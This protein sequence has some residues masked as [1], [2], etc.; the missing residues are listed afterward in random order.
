M[1]GRF[2]EGPCVADLQR[3]TMSSKAGRRLIFPKTVDF[4]EKCRIEED[5]SNAKCVS[6]AERPLRLYYAIPGNNSYGTKTLHTLCHKESAH[7][8]FYEYFS[9][10]CVLRP[11]WDNSRFRRNSRANQ[12]SAPEV[13]LEENL[14]SPIDLSLE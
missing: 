5:Y 9:S 4:F 1:E 3:Y 8:R 13:Q 6:R 2:W 12:S 11:L 14:L 7:T 10:R